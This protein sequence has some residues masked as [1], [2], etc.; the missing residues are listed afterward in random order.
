M[1]DAGWLVF[2]IGVL[3]AV[4]GYGGAVTVR[5]GKLAVAGTF[6]AVIAVLAI[7]LM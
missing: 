3:M 1:T 7:V 4:F 6:G 2:V 5:F